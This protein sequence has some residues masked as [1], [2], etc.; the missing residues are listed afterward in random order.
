M[1]DI[2]RR[3]VRDNAPNPTMKDGGSSF[4]LETFSMI[5][6]LCDIKTYLSS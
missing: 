4:P 5:V 3:F 6:A 1:N 2:G